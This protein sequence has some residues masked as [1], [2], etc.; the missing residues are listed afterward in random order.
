MVVADGREAQESEKNKEPKQGNKCSE[1]V[2]EDGDGQF[3]CKEK[4]HRICHLAVVWVSQG[5]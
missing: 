3:G 2:S 4:Q 1:T 5:R